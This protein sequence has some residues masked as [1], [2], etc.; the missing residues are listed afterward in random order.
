MR[1][2]LSQFRGSLE[3]DFIQKSAGP[4]TTVEAVKVNGGLGFWIAGEPHEFVYVDERG[5]PAFETL[6]LASNTLVWEAGR[7]TLRLEGEFTKEEALR[8]AESLD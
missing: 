2:L 6:R 3:R 5:Q 4:R 1:A 7:E 8:I